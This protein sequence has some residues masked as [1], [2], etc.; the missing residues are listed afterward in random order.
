MEQGVHGVHLPS[1]QFL[2][3]EK[4]AHGRDSSTVLQAIPPFFGLTRMERVWDCKPPPH[5]AVHFDHPDHADIAQSMGQWNCP[6]RLNISKRGHLT[7]QS[8]FGTTISRFI[9]CHPPHL[10]GVAGSQESS[11]L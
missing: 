4:V 2:S 10:Y 5:S 1:R 6:Q 8:S 3:Q 9:S 11:Q 7:P